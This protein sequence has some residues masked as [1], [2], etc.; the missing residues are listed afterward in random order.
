M[1]PICVQLRDKFSSAYP[2]VSATLGVV[3]NQRETTTY[4]DPSS[5]NGLHCAATWLIWR[6]LASEAPRLS[7]GRR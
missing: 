4:S 2:K 1:F 5:R 7:N 3:K 6:R